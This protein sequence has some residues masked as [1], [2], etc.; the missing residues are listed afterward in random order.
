MT[1]KG[2]TRLPLGGEFY[3]TM[4]TFRGESKIHI[5]KFLSSKTFHNPAQIYLVPTKNGVSLTTKQFQALKLSLPSIIP[6]LHPSTSLLLSQHFAAENPRIPLGDDLYLCLSCWDG[7]IK[8]HIRKFIPMKII[9]PN[10]NLDDRDKL[11]PTKYGICL[12]RLQ[13]Y[14]L[15]IHVHT[16]DALLMPPPPSQDSLTLSVPENIPYL[17]DTEKRE[18]LPDEEDD[19]SV[20]MFIKQERSLFI[21]EDTTFTPTANAIEVVGNSYVKEGN[22]SKAPD[23][24][25]DDEKHYRRSRCAPYDPRRRH[26][27]VSYEE[28]KKDPLETFRRILDSNEHLKRY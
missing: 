17:E 12:T 18:Q 15:N 23:D 26:K 24:D 5:R 7:E 2:D 9:N 10:V 11:H 27:R 20:D 13:I 22:N 4:N 8:V 25:D 19:T 14:K 21:D 28:P 3:L 16:I 6:K 1:T